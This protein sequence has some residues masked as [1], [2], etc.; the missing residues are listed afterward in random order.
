[1]QAILDERG[2]PGRGPSRLAIFRRSD[3]PQRTDPRRVGGRL[4]LLRE[5]GK[6]DSLPGPLLLPYLG[7]EYDVESAKTESALQNFD[8]RPTEAGRRRRNPDTC[9]LHGGGLRAGVTL[10]ARNDGARMAHATPRRCGAAGDET[11]HGL[12]AAALAFSDEELARIPLGAA[13]DLADHYDG[14]GRRVGE[15]HLQHIDELGALDRIASDADRG[16]LPEPFTGGLEH[17]L[18]GQRA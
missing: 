1:M 5:L 17:R 13:A 2:D 18:I 12:A 14:L 9:R 15:Q 16:G 10:A 4:C 7:N 11:H 8:K 6:P 3:Q